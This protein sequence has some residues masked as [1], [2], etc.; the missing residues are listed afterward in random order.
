MVSISEFEK[1]NSNMDDFMMEG[2][3][4]EKNTNQKQY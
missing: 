1:K 2:I 4:V 3:T